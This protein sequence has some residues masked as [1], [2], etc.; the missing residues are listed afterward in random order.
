ML[1]AGLAKVHLGVD[2]TRQDMKPGRIDDLR[3][4]G[5][6]EGTDCRDAARAH[7]DIANAHAI[8]V[9]NGAALNQQIEWL[10]HIRAP[11]PRSATSGGP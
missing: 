8:L 1:A 11:I 2:D 4:G 9:D 10:G 5:G 6:A 7:A 3:G